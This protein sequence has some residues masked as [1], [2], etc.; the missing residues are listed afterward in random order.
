MA[1]FFLAWSRQGSGIS[2]FMWEPLPLLLTNIPFLCEPFFKPAP[3]LPLRLLPPPF[4]AFRLDDLT[5][6]W[7]ETVRHAEWLFLIASPSVSPI[8]SLFFSFPVRT[9]FTPALFEVIPFSSRPISRVFSSAASLTLNPLLYSPLKRFSPSP[10]LQQG[11]S[12]I[13]AVPPSSSLRGFAYPPIFCVL[14]FS[15]F[16]HSRP[17][18]SYGATPR[19]TPRW[20]ERTTPLCV[21]LSHFLTRTNLILRFSLRCYRTL[22]FT[23]Y[24]IHFCFVALSLFFQPR[25]G[26]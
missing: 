10:F 18:F 15:I 9:V 8:I 6:R 7:P 19:P 2:L 13:T 22:F 1:K 26:S 23:N 4:L 20:I 12:W 11:Q 25:P 5:T 14:V 3:S 16:L 24:L 21:D 17:P